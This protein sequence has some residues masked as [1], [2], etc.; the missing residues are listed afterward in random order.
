MAHI[1]LPEGFPGITALVAYRP[2]TGDVLMRLADV[3]LRGP[4]P[5]SRG[6]RELIAASVS[7]GNDCLFCESTHGACAAR[8]LEGGVQAV[9][10]A[11]DETSPT[12]VGPKMHSLL[13]LAEKVRQ[14]GRSVTSDDVAKAKAQ[15]ANDLEIHDT[16]LI[17]A[18]FCMYNRYVDGLGTW[19][20]EA[21]AAYDA[22]AEI[23][24]E[25]GYQGTLSG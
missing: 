25:R 9:A 10:A 14:G 7:H 23:L 12:A 2:D 13:R 18:A 17:A 6:E 19:A 15:G 11:L 4:S 21:P 20:P 22:M 5:L 1:G 24:L 8:E 3:L 16:V